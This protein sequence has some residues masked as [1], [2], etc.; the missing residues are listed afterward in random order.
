MAK[1][2]SMSRSRGQIASVY[3]PGSFFTFEGGRGACVAVPESAEPAG[4]PA[5]TETQIFEQIREYATVWE[6]RARRRS[7]DRGGPGPDVPIRLAVDRSLVGVGGQLDLSRDQFVFLAPSLMG[8]VPEPMSFVCKTCGL[9]ATIPDASQFTRQREQMCQGC[10]ERAQG[11]PCYGGWEQLD[12]VWVH[13]SGGWDPITPARR[14]V[15]REGLKTDDRC[16]VCDSRRYRLV[17][18]GPQFSD[19]YFE[20]TNPA[21]RTRREMIQQDHDTLKEIGADVVASA[22]G[23]VRKEVNMEP[24]SYRASVAYYVHGDRLLVFTEN[25]W[26]DLLRAEQQTNLY[27]FL[28]EQ[29]NYPVRPLS[30]AEKVEILRQKGREHEWTSYQSIARA[31]ADLEGKPGMEAT[32]EGLRN[33]MRTNEENWAEDFDVARA[34]VPLLRNQVIGRI[35]A[36]RFIKRYDPM[37]LAVEHKTLEFERILTTATGRGG[38]RISTRVDAPD[39]H[40]LPDG[41]TAPQVEIMNRE[42]RRRLDAIGIE[43]MRLVREFEICEYSFGFTRT[44]PYPTTE[45]MQIEMPVR[46]NLFQKVQT[47]GP[48][49]ARHP[50]YA[51]RQSNE[52]FYVR[53]KEPLVCDW[54]ERNDVGVALAPGQRLGG[55]LIERFIP[56]NF[57]RF[58][59]AYRKE[60]SVP[61]DP[62]AYVFSLLH[63]L[64]H[65]MIEVMAELSGLDQG[66]FGEHLFVPDLAFVVYRRGMT[67]DLG[68]L[69]AMW[70]NYSSVTVGN[71]VIETLVHPSALRC[72]TGSLCNKRGGACPDCIMIPETSCLC[73]NNLLSRSF[74][75]GRGVPH[76]DQDKTTLAGYYEVAQAALAAASP[77]CGLPPGGGMGL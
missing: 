44:S 40:L 14:I 23:H 47:P 15:T 77:A 69:S 34:D 48:G 1:G 72:G 4:L 60:D 25:R 59:D 71:Q 12:V 17:R 67:M 76:W 54:L 58:V 46:L 8:Y 42:T 19:W 74:L 30:D 11:R 20:C 35:D 70:R 3:A 50:I 29:F 41:M 43:D 61:R 5:L 28:L 10:P 31:V 37:R 18:G 21:C 32:V 26:I 64:S 16:Q 9:L 24:T 38:R 36:V 7:A 27:G 56:E 68:N 13:W 22:N 6:T 45:R 75:G 62:Y 55:P 65:A 33:A 57:T 73:G 39:E 63:T 51:Q 52:A 49:G 66:S 2:P 53:L